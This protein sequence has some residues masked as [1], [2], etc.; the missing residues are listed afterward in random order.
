[1]LLLFCFYG[2]YAL[3]KVPQSEI[4]ALHKVMEDLET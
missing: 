1:M 2:G 4:D 3:M